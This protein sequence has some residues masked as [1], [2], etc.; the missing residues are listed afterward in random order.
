V[1]PGSIVVPER[2]IT[3]SPTNLNVQESLSITIN[4]DKEFT[5]YYLKHSLIDYGYKKF[6]LYVNGELEDSLTV[7]VT[8]DGPVRAWMECEDAVPLYDEIDCYVHI[9]NNALEDIPV[10]VTKVTF[11]GYEVWDGENWEAVKVNYVT[12]TS[13]K[14]NS[15]GIVGIDIDVDGWLAERVYGDDYY[16]YLFLD[17]GQPMAHMI[18][19]DLQVANKH[20]TLGYVT[21][22]YPGDDKEGAKKELPDYIITGAELG[23]AFLTVA[24]FV[25]AVGEHPIGLVIAGIGF[26]ALVLT[27]VGYSTYKGITAPTPIC[28]WE[29]D[30]NLIC[31]G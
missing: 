8:F 3:L 9:L 16:I 24:G 2:I 31:G 26:G 12:G 23:G 13:V 17:G 25:I 18:T 19:V 30:N 21:M 22:I 20:H 4:T 5:D 14:G 27:T 6:Y 29:R 10:Q 7:D 11:S 15:E 1:A 28:S